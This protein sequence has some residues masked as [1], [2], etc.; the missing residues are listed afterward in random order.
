MQPPRKENQPTGEFFNPIAL[1]RPCTGAWREDTSTFAE[2]R[3][4]HLFRR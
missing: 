4:A 1:S 2:A 3:V